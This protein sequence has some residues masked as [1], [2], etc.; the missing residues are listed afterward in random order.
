MNEGSR[1]VI[2]ISGGI[3]M[4]WEGRVGEAALYGCGCWAQSIDLD[5][6]DAS[7]AVACSVSGIGEEIIS[8][9]LA[10]SVCRELTD[11]Q[12]SVEDCAHASL[13]HF[14]NRN[15]RSDKA[16]QA[17][18]IALRATPEDASADPTPSDEDEDDDEGSEDPRASLQGDLVVAHS[19]DSMAYGFIT[20]DLRPRVRSLLTSVFDH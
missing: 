1:V 16:R 15:A 20:H 17:G 8:S 18:F 14:N 3:A 6:T 12:R 9:L 11:V 10:S 19:T 7:A 4:K 13:A 5:R 2:R